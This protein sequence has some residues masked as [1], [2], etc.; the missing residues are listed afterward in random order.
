M[1]KIF[2]KITLLMVL[3][4]AMIV[5][6]C[7]GG[8]EPSP[9]PNEPPGQ[10]EPGDTENPTP[11]D[12]LAL[13]DYLPLTVG[14]TWHYLG[15][16]NEY[17]TFT[18]E[19]VFAQGN[20]AQIKEDNGGTVSAMVFET[21]EDT[22]TVVFSQAESYE[23][24]NFLDAKS[25]DDL[26]ILKTPLEIGTKWETKDSTREIIDLNAALETP[27]G[28]F[29]QLVKVEIIFPDSTMYEYYKA[30]VGLIKREFSSEGFEVT[31]TLE[32]YEIK[33]Q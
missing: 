32:E 21:T 28:A 8:K 7:S 18:R 27:A 10:E 19:A 24:E 3:I 11:S 16:G 26:I 31:S 9:E 13:A 4:L 30:G 2:L 5:S 29:E 33:E 1:K 12:P 22:I 6:G 14:N 17:A 25:N 23:N 20:R 15:E